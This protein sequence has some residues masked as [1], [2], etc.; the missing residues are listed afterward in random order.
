M[1]AKELMIGDLMK[2]NS[3]SWGEDLKDKY[4]EVTFLGNYIVSRLIDEPWKEAY[5]ESN[6][7]EPITPTP[8]ILEKNGFRKY[9]LHEIKG[10]H[11]WTWW[12]DK[13]TSVSLWYRELNDDP[14]DGMMVRVDS[15]L[16]H[17]CIKVDYL[18]QLQH[19]LRL[20]GI[21]KEIIL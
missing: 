15:P 11:Q 2:T 4:C 18:H 10:Q 19:A 16:V 12:D 14:K 3:T 7:F 1:E 9:N 6:S 13:S 5:G 21:E 20:C 17:G 8:E